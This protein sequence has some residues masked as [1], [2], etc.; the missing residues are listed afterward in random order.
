MAYYAVHK[1]DRNLMAEVVRQCGLYRDVLKIDQFLNW[2]HIIGPQSQDEGLWSTGNG[3]AGYG[4]VRVLHT[5]QKWSGSKDMT[6][7][8][9]K[10]KS[11]IKEILDGAM[12]SGRDDKGLFH[13]YLNDA[14]W[15]G[16]VSGTALLA[17]I[18]YRMA[19][20]DPAMFPQKYIDWAD[21]SRHAL[22]GQ[23]GQDGVVVPAVNP[24]DW[25]DRNKY[26]NGS[27]EG[28][29]FLVNLYTAYRDCKNKGVCKN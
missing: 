15:F 1:N 21:R 25:H 2:R 27:P 12:L 4:M 5:L 24:Y 23:Q 29:A 11:W 14:G 13:N 7:E 3:W 26:Y 17:A 18:A 28:Q 20:N 9:G 10:L 16:E 22:G 19:V 8:A 6:D